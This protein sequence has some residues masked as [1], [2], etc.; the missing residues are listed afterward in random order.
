LDVGA[1]LELAAPPVVVA[2]APFPEP[3]KVFGCTGVIGVDGVGVGGRS[4]SDDAGALA[5]EFFLF[6]RYAQVSECSILFIEKPKRLT[7]RVVVSSLPFFFGAGLFDCEG[8]G[9]AGPGCGEDGCVRFAFVLPVT[10]ACGGGI[11]ELR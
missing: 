9:G 1:G 11:S 7:L 3:A 4:G 8:V 5:V 10:G 2:S 6:G